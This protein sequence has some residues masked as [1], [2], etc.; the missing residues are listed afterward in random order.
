MTL[1]LLL[2]LTSLISLADIVSAW[3]YVGD[4]NAWTIDLLRTARGGLTVALA[5]WGMKSAYRTGAPFL[6]GAL[7]AAWIGGYLL[8][9]DNNIDIAIVLASATKLALP[10]LLLAVG[11]GALRRPED[12]KI[13]ALF[14]AGLA[15]L[16]TVFGIWDIRHTEFWTD[17]LQYG[18]YL[19]GVKGIVAGFDGYY[20][21][22]FNFFGFEGKR[23]AAGLLAAP[24]AQGSFVAIGAMM[25][26][27]A[28]HR[29][30]LIPALG[31]LVVGMLG[32]W[33]SGTRGAMLI[34]LIAAPTYLMFSGRGATTVRNVAI[35]AMLSALSFEAIRSVYAYSVNLQDGSTIGHLDALRRNIEE[36]DQAWLTGPGIGAAGSVAADEGLRIAG[37]GE[38]SFFAIVYQ[39]GLPAALIFL[40]F[41]AS[42]LWRSF[43][44]RRLPDPAGD[45]SLAVASLGLGIATTFISSDHIFSL[46]G[47]GVFWI[48]LG[49]AL[50]Q[51]PSSRPGGA[52]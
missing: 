11:Y 21:L 3:L 26:F 1:G 45:L 28:L 37:G 29:R 7:Y 50:A 17:T 40:A 4:P 43:T 12:L 2:L 13:F 48:A 34:L 46:S 31:I 39:L 5:L 18:H 27:A 44:L 42:S 9:S 22:P 35:L 16:S 24:L 38:G 32:I 47:M 23:R 52:S 20:V 15:C 51:A 49:G 33:Q 14:L 25:G 36:L 41:Y 8:F 6:L 30:A 19:H 10:L